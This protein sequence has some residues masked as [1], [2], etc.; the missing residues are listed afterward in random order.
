[1]SGLVNLIKIDEV[2]HRSNRGDMEKRI[3]VLGAKDRKLYNIDNH[4]EQN[5]HSITLIYVGIL[6]I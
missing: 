4:I 2:Y 5:C 3:F 6:P 1:M